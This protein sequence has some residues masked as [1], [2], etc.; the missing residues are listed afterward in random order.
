MPETGGRAPSLQPPLWVAAEVPEAGPDLVR[1]GLPPLLAPILARRGVT[2][3]EEAAAFLNPSADQLHDPFLLAGLPE[4]VERLVAAREK[5][6]KVAIVGDYDVDGVTSTA[7]LSAVFA[8]CGIDAEAVLPHR[9]KE[10]YGFQPVHV[11][12]ALESGCGLIVTVDCGVTASD[13]IEAARKDCVDV[14]ITDHHL[15]GE[16]LPEGTILVN[17]RQEGCDYPF[18]DLAGVGLALKLALGLGQALS[19]HLPL[20]ALLRIAC[21]GTIADLAPLRGENRV[22]ASLGLAALA[23]TRSA[24]LLA[25]MDKAGVR[26]PYTA[27]DVAFRL[28]PRLNAAGR[29]SSPDHALELLMSRDRLQAYNLAEALDRQNR[30]RQDEERRVVDEARELILAREELPSILVAWSEGWHRGVVGIAAGRLARELARPTVLLAVDGDQAVGSGRSVPGIALHG[31]LDRWS[32]QL[33]RF[34]G[35]AQAVGMSAD[36]GSLEALRAAW[37]EAAAEEWPADLLRHRYEYELRL[38]PEEVGRD[39]LD[40]LSRLAPFGQGNPEPLLRVGPL[41]LQGAP[42]HFGKGH[43]SARAVGAEGGEEIGLLGWRWEDRADDLQGEFEVLA[44]LEEDTYRSEP[45]LR[46]LDCRPAAPEGSEP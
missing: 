22:I 17:P 2:S 14:I 25:L 15:P 35:H 28:G 36:P 33:L 34:G 7:L 42:R 31:F 44:Y 3:A 27:Q 13:G 12:K 1:A 23:D 30:E 5:G 18:T 16:P 11:A 10:G 41:R 19:I 46:L 29:L 26:R 8:R 9:L 39:L 32:E 6:E 45:V 21:L 4:A 37:E 40:R 24:G 20:D 43:I 38:S